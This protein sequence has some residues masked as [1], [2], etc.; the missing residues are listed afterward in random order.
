[1]KIGILTYYKVK[2]FGANLQ[3]IS[4][5][6]Y[7]IKHGHQPVFINY[8][9]KEGLIAIKNGKDNAQWQ[10]HLCF[11][12]SII[13]EQTPICQTAKEVLKVVDD[14]NIEGIIVG[15]DAVLQHHPFI[16][17]I[18]KAKRKLIFI[19][20]VTSDRL[21]PNLCWGCGMA[22][23]VPMVLMSVSSQ[24]SEYSL[25]LPSTKK[26]M[27]ATLSN[28]KLI[29]VRDNW[30]RDMVRNL[31]GKDVL[32]TPDPVFALNQN[33]PELIPSKEEILHKF[34]LPEK[35]A[36]LSL[37]SQCLSANTIAEL[38]TELNKEGI[39]FG[40]L[41][42]PTGVHFMHNADFEIPLPLS[43]IDWYALLKYS[44]AYIG[45]NMHP[46]VTCL[47]NAVPCF[48]IDNWGRTNFWGKKIDDGS[49]K[50]EHIMNVFGV[51][52]NHRMS[53][54]GKCNVSASEI[55]NGIKTFPTKLVKAKADEYLGMYNTMMNSLINAFV[56]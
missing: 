39:S 10:E 28:I 19:M 18:K 11:V 7:L 8:I 51:S 46:I 35:Y 24:N 17:R 34:H 16:T 40:I 52:R 12:D 41:P 1:M 32:I 27:K 37:F 42:L 54:G 9:L 44:C 25:F 21:F 6:M 2:N 45:C 22:D 13:K 33:V 53:S 43:P 55:V 56:K 4:T 49:S 15:S 23:K 31:T 36:L 48:S 26:K 50:V 20:P 47:H 38:K 14:Y 5:Y 30:T 3:A 29:T